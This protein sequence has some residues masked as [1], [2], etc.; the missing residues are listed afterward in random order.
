MAAY[1]SKRREAEREAAGKEKQAGGQKTMKETKD[2]LALETY[3][4]VIPLYARGGLPAH[5]VLNGL[6]PTQDQLNAFGITVSYRSFGRHKN[7]PYFSSPGPLGASKAV[8]MSLYSEDPEDSKRL[9]VSLLCCAESGTTFGKAMVLLDQKP[10]DPDA[11]ERVRQKVAT[12]LYGSGT[13]CF[14]PGTKFRIHFRNASDF[15]VKTPESST[16]VTWLLSAG[17]SGESADD[18]AEAKDDDESGSLTV[19]G[20]RGGSVVASRSSQLLISSFH[21]NRPPAIG[22]IDVVDLSDIAETRRGFQSVI[23]DHF[24]PRRASA[25]VASARITAGAR[26]T[27][28]DLTGDNE[29]EE[30]EEYCDEEDEDEKDPPTKK[31]RV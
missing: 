8:A 7:V 13:S 29:E 18:G 25:I 2:M 26:S 27:F 30:E 6:S 10:A 17:G 31:R 11:P 14:W 28:V 4:P 16:L 3:A 21:S 24:R 20:S 5:P 12:A 9:V 23:G 19:P 22:Q 1:M 15:D